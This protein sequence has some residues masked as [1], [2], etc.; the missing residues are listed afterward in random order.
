MANSDAPVISLIAMTGMRTAQTMQITASI[1]D[2]HLIA[3]L[4]TGSTHNFIHPTAA[5]VEGLS[6]VGCSNTSV[7]VANDDKVACQGRADQVTL[8]V[9]VVPFT[10]SLYAIPPYARS[11][12]RDLDAMQLADGHRVQWQGE[13]TTRSIAAATRAITWPHRPLLDDLLDSFDDVFA[14][15]SGMPPAH[16]YDHCIHLQLRTTPVAV[17]PYRYS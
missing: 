12:P 9:N 4:S 5:V 2:H 14:T 13:R 7:M 11:H 16:P 6:F 17:R 8:S 1:N 10:T 3:L 15:P